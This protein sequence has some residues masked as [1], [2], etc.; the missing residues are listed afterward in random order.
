[1]PRVPLFPLN[2]VLF[3]GQNLP[4]HIFEDRY[5]EMLQ[6]CLKNQEPFGIVLIKDGGRMGRGTPHSIGTLARV[7]EAEE[8]A[9]GR[10]TIA[11][12][13]RDS[14]YHIKTRGEQRFRITSLDRREASYLVGDIELYPDEQANEP[15]M[16]MVGQRVA[17]L[18]DEYY[19]EV[20]AL[21][22]G[23]QREVTPGERTMMFDMAML[24]R[25]QAGLQSPEEEGKADRAISV[26]ILPEEPSSLANVIAAELNVQPE[27]RQELL[28]CPSALARLQREAELLAEET[29]QIAERLK[30][31]YRRRFSEF[32][33]TN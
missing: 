31:H 15:A 17:V 7:T 19:R 5:K 11:M 3:P 8:M 9:P 24:V 28:E 13:H 2:L 6:R 29:P 26:P 4:L 1:M 12:P 20:V 10:C 23:W 30:M 32:G 18:F 33:R 14:C 16:L 25:G 22:G 27:V 21:M